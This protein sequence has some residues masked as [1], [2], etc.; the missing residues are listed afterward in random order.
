MS[1]TG[2]PSFDPTKARAA[3][4]KYKQETGKDLTFTLSHTADPDTTADAELIQQMLKQNA[5]IS[6]GLNP[7]PDQ[8]TLINNAIGKKYDAVLWRNHPGADDDTQYVWWHCDNGVASLVDPQP[9]SATCNNPVNFGGFND[10]VINKDFDQA[11]SEP[12]PTKRTALYEDINKE[13]AKQLWNLWGQWVI[14]TV[15]YANTVHGILG[16]NLPDGTAPF[17]GLPT[18]HPV[19]GIWCT[20]GKCS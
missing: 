15:G 5:G 13:F 19:E 14:W 2:L 9:A 12:D 4:A 18:G 3:A 11:R 20:G 10:P 17:E 16:P 6:I 1:D 7:V 8:S